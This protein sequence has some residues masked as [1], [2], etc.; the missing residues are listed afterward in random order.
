MKYVILIYSNP[1]SRALWN[2]FSQSEKAPGFHAYEL[3]TAELAASGE[4][5]AAEDRVACAHFQEHRRG[6][7]GRRQREE[8]RSCNRW[9]SHGFHLMITWPCACHLPPGVRTSSHAVLR[10]AGAWILELVGFADGNDLA[11]RT[12]DALA[13]GSGAPSFA[14]GVHVTRSL[15]RLEGDAEDVVGRDVDQPHAMSRSRLPD[16]PRR[17]LRR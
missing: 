9:S 11:C 16:Q 7:R 17:A 6:R 12:S 15:G 2:E 10:P 3:L 5:L 13:A 14:T 1:K 8:D 4:L